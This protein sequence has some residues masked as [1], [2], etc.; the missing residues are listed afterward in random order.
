[1]RSGPAGLWSHRHKAIRVMRALCLLATPP[2]PRPAPQLPGPWPLG[3]PFSHSTSAPQHGSPLRLLQAWLPPPGG[4]A[5]TSAM[6]SL[7]LRHPG[8]VAEGPA[9]HPLLWVS[10]HFKQHLWYIRGCPGSP[11]LGGL[12]KGCRRTVSSHPSPGCFLLA[13]EGRAGH[14][15]AAAFLWRSWILTG[16]CTSN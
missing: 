5:M 2:F 15:L 10:L 12:A 11:Q 16:F 14:C 8:C 4:R 1:M 7:T 6:G 3:E 13:V 9:C